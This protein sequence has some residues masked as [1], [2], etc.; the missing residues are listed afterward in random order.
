MERNITMG[1][2]KHCGECEKFAY[3]DMDGYGFCLK[4][5]MECRCSDKCHITHGKAMMHYDFDLCCNE[6]C[7]KRFDCQRY[8]TYKHGEWEHCYVM[9]GCNDFQLLKQVTK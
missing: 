6:Q 3:E 2:I 8:I 4:T 7:P 1:K 5:N 9:R